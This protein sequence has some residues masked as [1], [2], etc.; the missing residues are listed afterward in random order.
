MPIAFSE[1]VISVLLK[2][3]SMPPPAPA[4]QAQLDVARGAF[5]DAALVEGVARALLVFV[6]HQHRVVLADQLF[7]GKAQQLRHAVVHEG[8]LAFVVQG[9][10]DV[11]R[12]IHQIAVHLFRVF[13]LGGDALVVDRQA[14]LLQRVLHRLEQLL[15][16]VRLAQVIVGAALE[17][18]D[19]GL[20]ADVAAHHDHVAVDLA[21]VDVIHDLVAAHVGQAQVEQ[22]QIEFQFGQLGQ[23]FAAA[24]GGDQMVVA[25]AQQFVQR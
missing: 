10:D 20:D 19:G 14:A 5:I 13:Q 1:I 3:R 15:A 23:R 17:R 16:A 2:V 9:V 18:A 24:G 4:L 25:V 22:D 8:E 11:R 7:A 6:V 21:R 12:R